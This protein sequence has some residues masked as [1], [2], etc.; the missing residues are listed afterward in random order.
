MLHTLDV[1]NRRAAYPCTV[2]TA[3][4]TVFDCL[5]D[6]LSV[7]PLETDDQSPGA[8]AH[9][10]YVATIHPPAHAMGE[11]LGVLELP[12]ARSCSNTRPPAESWLYGLWRLYS[13]RRPE[14]H[15]RG[16]LRL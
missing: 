14:G 2:D 6:D 12:R 13:L 3:Q 16:V 7:D 4:F 8:F 15:R 9:S 1:G 5:R 10:P 11:Y